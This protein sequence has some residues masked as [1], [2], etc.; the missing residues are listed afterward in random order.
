MTRSTPL[1]QQIFAVGEVSAIT[2]VS[3][4][5]LHNWDRVTHFFSPSVKS[6]A[7]SGSRRYYNAADLIALD[8]MCCLRWH[9]VGLEVAS[10]V[11]NY[12][13]SQSDLLHLPQGETLYVRI[14]NEKVTVFRNQ[15][16]HAPDLKNQQWRKEYP[17]C[18]EGAPPSTMPGVTG[19]FLIEFHRSAEETKARIAEFLSGRDREE[20]R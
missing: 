16:F 19:F 20:R 3:G 10:L 9:N 17:L 14:S 5:V 2:G 11:G 18:P 6:A 7:G 12:V 8:V 15:S 1:D 4:A 13:R